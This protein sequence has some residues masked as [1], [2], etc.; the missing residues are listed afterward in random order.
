MTNLPVPVESTQSPGLTIT[1]ALWNTGVRDAVNFLLGPPIAYL[2]QATAQ[3]TTTA[4]WQF[5]ALDASVNDSYGG[6]STT[7][8]NSRYV[9]QVPGWYVACGVA[10]VALNGTGARGARL[11]KNGTPIQGGAQMLQ[12]PSTDAATVSTPTIPIFLNGSGDFIEFHAY[13]HSGG[14]L[15]TFVASDLCSSLTIWFLHN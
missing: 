8:N 11:A 14:A 15:N 10:A 1:S 13:Q 7:A 6:H 5:V 12:A 2:T 9:G 3:G 4:V